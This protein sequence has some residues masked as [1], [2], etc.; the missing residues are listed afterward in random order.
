MSA[1]NR[2]LKSL[3]RLGLRLL[4]AVFLGL[5]SRRRSDLPPIDRI[6]R[7][8]VLRL[9]ERIGNG[10][11]LLP[12]LRAIRRRS[13]G[14]E[15]HL[16][17]HRPV[18]EL[19]RSCT[20]D[21]VDVFWD[22]DQR[23]LLRNPLRA[24]GILRRLRRRRFDLALSSSNP[25]GFS[26][27]QALLCRWCRPGASLGF[28]WGSA[29]AYFDR[30]VQGSCEKYYADAQLDL[31]RALDP[32]ALLERGGLNIEPERTDEALHRWSLEVHKPTA[33]LWMGATGSKYLDPGLIEFLSD[34]IPELS[35]LAVQPALAC[36]DLQLLAGLPVSIR[37]RTLVWE[38]PL[39]ETA[40]YFS[41]FHLFVSGDTGP[42]HLA[43]ALGLPTL[44][45]FRASNVTQYGYQEKQHNIALRLG[46]PASDR[47]AISE[48]L[49]NL[50]E[51]L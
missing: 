20:K 39:K 6:T 51:N 2:F 15:L 3:E 7:I 10:L 43:V 19:L 5:A 16:L 18:A 47:K 8:L 22:Y 46:E 26:V 14:V 48:A 4:N 27:S 38:R 23:A 49:L 24:L 25:D 28:D 17:L 34:R 37:E 45:L 21:L 36:G 30:V 50:A 42:L 13:P 41:A 9:D 31:W 40:L 44:A 11:M 1:V 12:L 32:R 33:L 29:S 35:G